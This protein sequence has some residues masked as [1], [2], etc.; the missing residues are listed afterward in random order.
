MLEPQQFRCGFFF[1]APQMT[2]VSLLLRG[3]ES[4]AR[5]RW[6]RQF[7]LTFALIGNRFN[8][9]SRDIFEKEQ[10]RAEI[11]SAQLCVHDLLFG[12]EQFHAQFMKRAFGL[13]LGSR[14]VACCPVCNPHQHD[15]P[16]AFQLA[17]LKLRL[18][19]APC[20]IPPC[21]AGTSADYQ[22]GASQF[23]K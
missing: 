15:E 1:S 7:L 16:L 8:A 12:A 19:A 17:L 20:H 2:W 13:F 18:V 6:L 4:R 10:P 11:F 23:A 9:L 22:N 21:T 14:S 5:P 3:S